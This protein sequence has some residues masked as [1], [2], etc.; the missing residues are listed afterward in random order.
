[1]KKS[2]N[3]FT[4]KEYPGGTFEE[5]PVYEKLI[6]KMT[7]EEKASLLC[8]K[9]MWETRDIPR[10]D[11]PSIFLADGPHGLRRQG[12]KGDF[13]GIRKSLPATCFPV[14]A[15]L[16]N[17]WDQVLEEAVGEALGEEARIQN[18]QILLG[19]GL[20]IKR[21]PLCG[22]NFEYFSEDPYLSGKMAAAFVR[23]IQSRGVGACPK[24]FAVNSQEKLRMASDSVLDERTLREIYLTG[25]EIAVKEGRP[26]GIMSS[27][28]RINGVYASENP[29][30]LDRVLRRQWGF[31]GMVI[32]DWGASNDLAKGVE[33]G[34]NL[35]MPY[36]GKYSAREVADRVRTGQLPEKT[37][38]QRVRESLQV[39]LPLAQNAADAG[40]SVKAGT[41]EKH[42][43]LARKAAAESIVLLKNENGILPLKKGARVALIG[44]FAFKPRYQGAG[45]SLVNPVSLETMESEI[46]TSGL[47]VIGIARGYQR[48][49]KRNRKLEEEALALAGNA[50]AV[51][52]CFGLTEASESEGMDRKHMRLPENQ[53]RLLEQ[54]AKVNPHVI[55]ILSAGAPVEMPW[56]SCCQ[57]LLHGYL[58]G[59]GGGGAMLEVVTGR[60][61]P[62]GKLS[63]TYPMTYE[64]T[65]AFIFGSGPE[66]R[67]EYREG[68]FTGYRY[69]DRREIPVRFPFGFGLSYT[70]FSYSDLKTD[71]TGVSFTITNTGEYAGSEIAQLYVG[72]G[73]SRILRPK[74]ELKGF[75]KVFLEPG[76]SRSVNI[77][78][79]DMTFRFWD[80]NRGQ[81]EIEGGIYK[82]LVG[83]SV[84]DIRLSGEIFINGTEDVSDYKREEGREIPGE[85]EGLRT[86]KRRD[87]DKNS[88]IC[89]MRYAKSPV[90]RGICFLLERMIELWEKSGRS[91][92]NLLF[93]YNMT[94]RGMAKLT[95][96]LITPEFVN[97]LVYLIN[98]H[99]LKG[100][101]CLLKGLILRK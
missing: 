30:L 51:L 78:F 58:A 63:E 40:N 45:S 1:M 62:S 87:L 69:Y 85:K 12:K 53:T 80:T 31:Q 7:L 47:E 33:A 48:N 5:E 32:T 92:L 41:Y 27:Y 2:R 76:E 89:Q 34:C 60:V 68:I 83:A 38:D 79:D 93:V 73:E 26:K 49:G 18:V 24:H 21:N 19:P 9:N 101:G 65:P 10:L 97:G 3:D 70:S 81:W 90:A 94:F 11:I 28:N 84:S 95:G 25:F 71:E 43:Q 50:D 77:P 17:S 35:E 22:R 67:C 14:A 42:H 4:N 37:L 54:I 59:E 44:A 36:A 96:G 64:D 99:P 91:S 82:I 98:R 55:G 72:M 61:N 20:N 46:K 23:G 66:D 56:L 52:Y 6:E 15:C 39:I 16:S 29:Y 57:G 13:L 100:V 8:G 74:K 88:A 75:K 86:Q